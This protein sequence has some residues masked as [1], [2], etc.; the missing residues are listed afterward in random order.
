MKKIESLQDFKEFLEQNREKLLEK[1]VN[2]EMLP[3]VDDWVT[4]DTWDKIY[5][6]EV[7]K[8]GSLSD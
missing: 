4:D 5:K 1:A 3:S 2:I 8:R 6:Q 7:V